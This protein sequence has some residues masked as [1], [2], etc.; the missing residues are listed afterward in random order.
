MSPPVSVALVGFSN[1]ERTALQ[2]YLR[3][4]VQRELVYAQVDEPDQAQLLI[5]DADQ[6]GFVDRVLASGRLADSVFVGSR[7]PAGASAWMTR[8]ID[9]LNVLRELDILVSLR[10]AA[11]LPEPARAGPTPEQ[12]AAS[13]ALAALPDLPMFVDTE[14]RPDS[15]PSSWASVIAP[16]QLAPADQAAEPDAP[17]ER[18]DVLLV[19]DSDIALRF[20]EKVVLEL[21]LTPQLADSARSAIAALART[22][23]RIVFL[24]VDLGEHSELDG[25]ELC[26]RIKREQIHVGDA[27]P[28]V[29]LISAHAAPLDRVRGELAGCDGYL[30][31]PLQIEQLRA[32]LKRNGVRLPAGAA[33]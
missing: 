16:E 20:L 15:A 22:A 6:A 7:A 29:V 33:R 14:P 10:T 4:A 18:V 2:S 11:T 8:P 21:G 1:F 32:L 28:Q 5:V 27:P 12:A 13:A 26:Q 24:D 9:P 17:P 31:K 25:L 19:D 3:L 23:F 30:G